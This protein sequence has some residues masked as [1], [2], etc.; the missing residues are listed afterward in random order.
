[1]LLHLVSSFLHTRSLLVPCSY[2]SVESIDRIL[3]SSSELKAA[4]LISSVKTL[5]P[6]LSN[7]YCFF[8]IRLLFLWIVQDNL[9]QFYSILNGLFY[10]QFELLLNSF[11]NLKV[12]FSF[13]YTFFCSFS[14]LLL[15]V[16]FCSW[17]NKFLHHLFA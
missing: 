1:M 2:V 17:P 10:F 14:F 6:S 7:R 3:L 16:C 11:Y 12:N 15:A 9:H 4:L 13:Y 8:N 5:C